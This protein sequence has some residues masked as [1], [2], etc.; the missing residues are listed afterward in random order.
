MCP[1]IFSLVC[2]F[3]MQKC[4]RMK[5]LVQAFEKCRAMNQNF[6]IKELILQGIEHLQ[7]NEAKHLKVLDIFEHWD[8][9]WVD[10]CFAFDIESGVCIQSL[11]SNY[12]SP[13]SKRSVFWIVPNTWRM[14][15][16]QQPCSTYA[17]GILNIACYFGRYRSEAEQ[18]VSE[19]VLKPMAVLGTTCSF[20]CSDYIR[21]IICPIVRMCL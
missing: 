7:L 19:L 8:L 13:H 21:L 20:R 3:G 9:I 18:S 16:V 1:L 12:Y 5:Y 11:Q 15:A 17:P 14:E 2:V 6:S 10:G 4:A